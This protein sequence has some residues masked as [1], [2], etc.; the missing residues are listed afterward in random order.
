MPAFKLLCTSREDDMHLNNS[1]KRLD[2]VGRHKVLWNSRK[3]KT[4]WWLYRR[5]GA[6][7]REGTERT[8]EKG[9]IRASLL[10]L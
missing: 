5:W 10:F 2:A 9:E 7:W 3:E 6:L 4:Q 1:I 8:A